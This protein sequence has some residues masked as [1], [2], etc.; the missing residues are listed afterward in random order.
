MPECEIQDLAKD[1][2]GIFRVYDP[3][4][5]VH[6]VAYVHRRTSHMWSQKLSRT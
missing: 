2:V 1:A 4:D 3:L 6:S 5:Q